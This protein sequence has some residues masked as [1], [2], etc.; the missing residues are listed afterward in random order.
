[1]C[2]RGRR[3]EKSARTMHVTYWTLSNFASDAGACSSP[4][5]HTLLATLTQILEGL[6]LNAW[7]SECGHP[8]LE[9][10]AAS[11]PSPDDILN[12]SRHIISKY[13]APADNITRTE[14]PTK[15]RKAANKDTEAHIP[16]PS[17]AAAEDP[18]YENTIL[19]TRDLLYVAELVSA[20]HTGDFGR[21]EDILPQIACLFRGAGSNNYST[22]VLHL[23]FNIKEVW[24]PEFA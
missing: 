15:K 12:I 14:P 18:V 20:M 21:I 3:D 2:R 6:I 22:E 17:P 13:T 4:D 1:M 19:L 7:L 11:N 23:L 8:T 24:T 10:F 16:T 5:Y 9:S